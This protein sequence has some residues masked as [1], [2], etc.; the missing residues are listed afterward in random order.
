[1]L[2]RSL[3]LAAFRNLLWDHRFRDI[4][5]YLETPKGR[6]DSGELDVMNLATLRKLAP[7]ASKRG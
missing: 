2:F 1:V 7:P 6:T 3:G 4:P 5:M